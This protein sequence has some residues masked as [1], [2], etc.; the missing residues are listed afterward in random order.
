M[1][2]QLNIYHILYKP[3]NKKYKESHIIL[4]NIIS[5]VSTYF[6]KF[7]CFDGIRV[8]MFLFLKML[9]NRINL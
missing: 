9:K 5:S 7:K 4:A 3:H 8:R 6:L 2:I 1:N